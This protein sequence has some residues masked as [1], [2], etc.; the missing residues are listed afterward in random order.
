MIL[1][2]DKT[3]TDRAAALRE[4][5]YSLG[6]PCAVCAPSDMSDHYPFR[7]IIT[8][9]DVLDEVRRMPFDSIHALVIGGFANSALNAEQTDGGMTAIRRAHEYLMGEMRITADRVT[10]FGVFL[11]PALFVSQDFV[12]VYGNQV[13]LSPR[14]NMIVK[15]LIGAT[16]ADTP[17]PPQCI[18]RFCSPDMTSPARS[19]GVHIS[20]INEKIAPHLGGQ[21]FFSIRG[22]GYFSSVSTY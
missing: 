18:A 6:C 2:V 9:G 4:S 5:L 21:L 22:K 17:A 7:L 14:E 12:E 11:P 3:I 20:H 8:Y 1:I 10:P 13:P 15:Y 16:S 19:V